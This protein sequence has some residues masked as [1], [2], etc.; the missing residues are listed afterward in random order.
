MIL[1]DLNKKAL[2]ILNIKKEE[3]VGKKL[4]DVFPYIESTEP[5]QAYLEVIKTGNSI[6]DEIRIKLNSKDYYFFVKAFKAGEGLGLTGLD[7]TSH[8]CMLKELQQTKSELKSANQNLK[9]RTEELEEFSYIS[10]HDLK[11]HL[12]NVNNLLE[13]L[14]EEQAISYVGKPIF[15]KLQRVVDVMLAKLGAINSVFEVKSHLDD[16]QNTIC[17]QDILDNITRE[18]SK[19]ISITNTIICADFSK[20]PDIHINAFHLHCLLYNLIINSIQYRSTD[21]DPIIEISTL[22]HKRKTVLRV[23]DNGIGFDKKLGKSKIFRLF[24]KMHTHVEGLGV[25][26]YTVKSIVRALGGRIRVNSRPNTGTTFEL[27]I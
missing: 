3:V 2:Q 1:R 19:E 12:T 20:C 11:G 8:V 9:D 14:A 16:I 10:S 21:R 27:V 6:E 25:G 17:F 7:I 13:M 22:S 18:I 23:K 5:L 26:L 24:R 15:S 4:I